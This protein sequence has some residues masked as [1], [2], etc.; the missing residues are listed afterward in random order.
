[1]EVPGQR[2]GIRQS[3]GTFL[4][5][6]CLFSQ[7][8]DRGFSLAFDQARIQKELTQ[9]E[10]QNKDDVEHLAMLEKHYKERILAYE[11]RAPP[12]NC[13]VWFRPIT[14]T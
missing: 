7:G 14:N 8:D 1:M 6:P 12:A 13:A 5:F 10:E 2:G 3:H 11:V 9:E 4:S